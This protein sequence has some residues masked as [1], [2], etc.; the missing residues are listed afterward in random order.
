MATDQVTA[1]KT[2]K[3]P[4]TQDPAKD[5]AYMI[6]SAEMRDL[7]DLK[8]FRLALQMIHGVDPCEDCPETPFRALWKAFKDEAD[9]DRVVKAILRVAA[10]MVADLCP[11]S[12]DSSPAPDD[13]SESRLDLLRKYAGLYLINFHPHALPQTAAPSAQST[14]EPD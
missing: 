11:S 12:H 13:T 8:E 1:T 10:S 3:Q 14:D 5:P 7:K 4:H 6:T 2:S 9:A